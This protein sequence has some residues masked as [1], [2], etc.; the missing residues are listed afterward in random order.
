MPPKKS[1]NA[2]VDRFVGQADN[3]DD[4][5]IMNHTL[6]PASSHLLSFTWMLAHVVFLQLTY[7]FQTD[8]LFNP[9]WFHLIPSQRDRF[10]TCII[11]SHTQVMSRSMP[12]SLQAFY[13]D[14]C[15][16]IVTPCHNFHNFDVH[17]LISTIPLKR[18]S[19]KQASSKPYRR[20]LH[21]PS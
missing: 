9:T 20:R 4:P 8:F 11:L 18:C 2:A 3:R 19:R 16:L 13:M 5:M 6:I 12:P 15:C 14:S 17:A 1:G 21:P 10:P 7:N